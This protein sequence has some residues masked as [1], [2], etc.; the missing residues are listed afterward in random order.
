MPRSPAVYALV[1]CAAVPL[2]AQSS[3]S[4]WLF[5]EWYEMEI[6]EQYLM[7]TPSASATAIIDAAGFSGFELAGVTTDCEYFDFGILGRSPGPGGTIPLPMVNVLEALGGE[8][9][10]GHF[11][12]PAFVPDPAFPDHGFVPSPIS[13]IWFAE[14][15]ADAQARAIIHQAGLGV[16]TQALPSERSYRVVASIA[17][18]LVLNDR[19]SA[20]VGHP[21]VQSISIHW[22]PIF[23]G[24]CPTGGGGGTT[25]WPPVA[26]QSPVDVP[27]LDPWMLVVLAAALAVVG[28]GSAGRGLH[29]ERATSYR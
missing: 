4:V 5:G 21:A 27:A 6:S 19:V 28:V 1:F 9:G 10:G 23:A 7:A 14:G 8:D 18:G 15:T 24:V 13:Q 26:G 29:H 12:A 20:L 2:Q 11:W 17:S 16:V 25:P 3:A 22:L